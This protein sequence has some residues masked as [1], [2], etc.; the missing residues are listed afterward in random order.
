MIAISKLYLSLCCWWGKPIQL[1][2]KVKT[3]WK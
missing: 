3:R 1:V 2:L